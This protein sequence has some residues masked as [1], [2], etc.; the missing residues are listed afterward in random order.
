L[1]T[2]AAIFFTANS[3]HMRLRF[4]S[5]HKRFHNAL[6]DWLLKQRRFSTMKT[7]STLLNLACGRD[8]LADDD[9]RA[10]RIQ[11]IIGGILGALVLSSIWGIAAGS[12]EL[13]VA[14]PNL[15]KLPMIILVS[16]LSALPAGLLTWKLTGAPYR[17]SEIGASYSSGVLSGGLV[18]AVLAPIVA[19]YYHSSETAGPVLAMGSV[20]LALV[21]AFIIFSRSLYRRVSL[22]APKITMILP[23]LVVILMFIATLVQL[24]HLAS[25]IL[26][27][28]TIFD[29]GVDRMLQNSSSSLLH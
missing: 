29:G 14:L 18:L 6:S 3:Q 26:P 5:R 8:A 20:F 17:S 9:S 4:K 27:E 28:Q 21:V 13:A 7:I 11:I 16:T 15:Y 12:R 23:A 24:I 1:A 25:P 10:K 22:H 19:L 2:V